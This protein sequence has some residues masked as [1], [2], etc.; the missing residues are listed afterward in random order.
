MKKPTDM[1]N[2]MR[3]EMWMDR[4][5][6]TIA[7]WEQIQQIEVPDEI[8]EGIVKFMRTKV[9]KSIKKGTLIRTFMQI[10]VS[11]LVY[12]KMKGLDK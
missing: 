10:A 6:E 12:I 4:V 3:Q 11:A 7:S 5:L 2:Y 9:K 8:K 1:S